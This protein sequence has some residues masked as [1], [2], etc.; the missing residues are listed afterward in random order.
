MPFLHCIFLIQILYKAIY[1][2]KILYHS[3]VWGQKVLFERNTLIHQGPEQLI[4]SDC[5]NIYNV[6]VYIFK[7]F[8]SFELLNYQKENPEKIFLYHIFHKNI[9]LQ[10][11]KH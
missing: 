11:F 10:L 6:K 1:I 7:K 9:K 4:K 8:C 5:K 3:N 2:F